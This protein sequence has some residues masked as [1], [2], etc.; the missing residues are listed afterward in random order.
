LNKRLRRGKSTWSAF[1]R[2]PLVIAAGIGIGVSS[3]QPASP[4]AEKSIA[5]TRPPSLQVSSDTIAEKP[6][7]SSI[8]PGAPVEAAREP[9][10]QTSALPTPVFI[11]SLTPESARALQA[12]DIFKECLD[13]PTMVV[14]PPG[15][16]AM[17][18]SRAEIDSSAANSN[19]GP[20]HRVL[21]SRRFALSRAEVTR[22]EFDAFVE[23]THY[24]YG[25]Q[26]YTIEDG[27][28]EE[29][30]DRSYRNP[31]FEQTA[32]HP[33]VCVDWSDAKAYVDWLSQVT[34]ASYRLPTEAE[35]E[36][37]AR[38]GGAARYGF[39]DD[40]A[41]LCKYANGADQSAKRAGLPGDP[42]FLDCTDGY[43]YTAPVGSFPANAF[44]L[45]DLQGNV[46]ELTADCYRDDYS[47]ASSDG[48]APAT[49]L[50]VARAVRGGSWSSPAFSL[51]PA[52]R[53][54]TIINKR[55]D[56]MGF[57]VARDLE[58]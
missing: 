11:E 18:S 24:P 7:P 34:G 42:D 23:A 52:V 29:R 20:Q 9:S 49:D 40:P 56:D 31:G 47:T 32:D 26:C 8:A 22:G 43:V 33:A 1:I 12:K 27:A 50:C 35:Y 13:C 17:G 30:G 48:S 38:A 58:P 3:A 45:L 51:R 55:Y 53:A 19:E 39:G 44:G 28:A 16:F 6:G 5:Q 46:W 21:I 54:R 15:S 4:D 25:N 41:E 2:G 36:Y 14:V 57:R 10:P 37:A